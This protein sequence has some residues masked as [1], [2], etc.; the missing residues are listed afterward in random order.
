MVK[1]SS[2][3]KSRTTRRTMIRKHHRPTKEVVILIIIL[4]IGGYFLVTQGGITGALV[5]AS[6]VP[7][8]SAVLQEL[9]ENG[10]A[11]VIVVLRERITANPKEEQQVIAAAQKQVLNS[12]AL[13]DQKGLLG[14]E[15]QEFELVHQY[16]TINAFSGSITKDGLDKLR[17]DYRVVGIKADKPVVLFLDNSVPLVN[18]RQLHNLPL[19]QTITGTG[20]TVCIVDTGIDYSHSAFGGCT[21]QQFLAGGCRV[22]GGYNVADNTSDPL[23][24]NGHGTHIAG[25][26]A[27][28]DTIYKGVAPG[29][30]LAAVKVFPGSSSGTTEAV[31]IA[32]IDW[33]ITHAVNL[34]ISVISLSLG[35]GSLN[36]ASCDSSSLG[37]A[38]NQAVDAGLLVSVAS[39]NNG[40]STGISSPACAS[41]VVS[42]GSTTVSDVIPA[43]SNSGAILDVLAPGSAIKSASA[44]GNFVPRT[45]TSMAAPHVSGAMVLIKQYFSQFYNYSLSSAEVELRLKKG[46]NIT[47]A[48]NSLVFPRLDLY[49]AIK[50]E[51][52]SISPENNFSLRQPYLKL[53][54]HADRAVA[55]ALAE[56]NGVNLTMA[57]NN[58]TAYFLNL[59]NISAGRRPYQIYLID[60]GGIITASGERFFTLESAFPS[61]RFNFAD[62]YVRGG[63]IVINVTANDDEEITSVNFTVA[64]GNNS[65]SLAGIA[66]NQSSANQSSNSSEQNWL[67]YLNT[68]LLE[69]GRWQIRAVVIDNFGNSNGTEFRTIIIDRTV[70]A[71]TNVG[72][73]SGSLSTNSTIEFRARVTDLNLKSVWVSSPHSGQLTNYSLS[74]ENNSQFV[75]RINTTVIPGN[76]FFQIYAQDLAY[77]AAESSAASVAIENRAPQALVITAPSNGSSFAEGESIAFSGSAEDPDG[78]AV[79]YSWNF[80]DGQIV[81]GPSVAHSYDAKKNYTVTLTAADGITSINA[82]ISLQINEIG[83]SSGSANESADSSSARSAGSGGSSSSGSSSDSQSSEI[84]TSSINEPELEE[85]PAEITATE[86]TEEIAEESLAESTVPEESSADHEAGNRFSLNLV[87][88]AVGDFINSQRA[89]SIGLIIGIGLLISIAVIYVVLRKKHQMEIYGLEAVKI[90]RQEKK[91]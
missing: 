73:T 39:G 24:L 89:V 64:K 6:E 32:G 65:V 80:G 7:V 57:S 12:M 42:V 20:Q 19:N 9:E 91:D 3:K 38:V 28:N 29:A 17:E 41:K 31:V 43:Y 16:T 62:S 71:I 49:L 33:C 83:G 35:D 79:A 66:A 55:Q 86:S 59:T 30:N 46:V 40:Y 14:I 72:V 76:H 21:Y 74:A 52:A 81:S 78:Q 56:V 44:A 63:I 36:N 37:I 22:V 58:S 48:R 60:F 70:P 13:E 26:V 87:G 15:Q 4:L 54:V 75:Y 34:S 88:A 51:M 77:N 8:D 82:M 25:I 84:A 18:A 50:P 11:E 69:E 90:V 45:G 2:M 27:S 68:S 47:D 23:D 85:P 10:Q 67:A 53:E 61:V 5:G 1:K